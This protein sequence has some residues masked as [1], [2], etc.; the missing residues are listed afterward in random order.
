MRTYKF[1]LYPTKKQ[2]ETLFKHF[3]LCRFIYNQ[4]LAEL[5]NNNTE[6]HIFHYITVLK[7]KQ[8]ELK[9]VY[10]KTLQNEAK[11]LFSNFKKLISMKK[12]GIKV[13]KLRFKGQERFKTI[14]YNQSGFKLINQNTRYNILHLSKIGDIKILQHREIEG[15]IK[16]IIIKRK[17]DSWEAHIV[18]DSKYQLKKGNNI[19]GIDLGVTSFLT[20]NNGNKIS[21]PL[22]YKQS[23]EKLKLL[24]QNLSKKKRG[25]NN[26][27]KTKI[28]ITK[29]HEYI[30]QQRND[31]LHKITTK[32]I[33]ENKF[34]GVEKLDIRNM[35][36]SFYNSRNINDSS[37]GKFLSM[38]DNKAESAGCQVVK[39]N[40]VNTTKECNKCG[41]IQDMPIWQRQY[42][43]QRCGMSMDRDTNSAKV[44][45]NR[46]LEQGT[47]E[48]NNSLSV[49]QEALTSRVVHKLI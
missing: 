31:F 13:G 32:L 24:Q 29:L 26:R 33:K 23:L 12:K 15:K 10:S 45:L 41:N 47:V 42:N 20:D 22:Y 7:K 14:H 38:L 39:V 30:V 21:N 49:K 11:K 19:I 2:E 37:W 1:R 46:A 8:P 5:S 9:Q 34:M 25:S 40:P 44:I 18:T 35:K 16:S 17:T 36:I 4:L 43:C 6:K 48:T 28:Q 3:D 27:Y